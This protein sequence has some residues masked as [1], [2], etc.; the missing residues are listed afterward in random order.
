MRSGRT[1]LPLVGLVAVAACAAPSDD[2]ATTQERAGTL[3]TPAPAADPAVVRRHVDSLNADFMTAFKAKD[4][5][6]LS[7]RYDADGAMMMS[8]MPAAK[9]RA[10]VEQSMKEMFGEMEV[11]D[12]K[13]TTDDV[14]VG[15][16]LAVETGRYEM[17]FTPKGAPE[18]TDKGKYITVWKRQSDGSWKIFRDIA[19][20]DV[21]MK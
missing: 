10:A 19:N 15:G 4:V 5:G 14:V 11:K 9:G 3:A 18:M 1:L 2:T 17:T 12:F 6:R 7:S 21:P 20:S 13:L 8:N 16:D